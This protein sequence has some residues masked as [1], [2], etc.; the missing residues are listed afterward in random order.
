MKK[1]SVLIMIA[2]ILILNIP[3][4]DAGDL[5]VITNETTPGSEFDTLVMEDTQGCSVLKIS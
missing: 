3:A 5:F 1:L 4:A 2:A